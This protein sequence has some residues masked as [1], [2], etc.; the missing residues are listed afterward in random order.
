MRGGGLRTWFFAGN[1]HGD[2]GTRPSRTWYFLPLAQNKKFW[3]HSLVVISD[4]DRYFPRAAV[5]R[6]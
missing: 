1:Q 3:R 6:G 2:P 5:P 4:V